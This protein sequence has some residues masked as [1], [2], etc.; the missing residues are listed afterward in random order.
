MKS[1]ITI[2]ES[3]IEDGIISRNKKFYP[4]SMTQEEIEKAFLNTRIKL[5][6]KYKFDGT[7]M[8]QALQ[9]NNLNKIEYPDGKYIVLTEKNMKKNDF[10]Y[11]QLPADIL[12]LTNKYKNTV[13]GH[14][15]ADCPILII[16]DRKLGVTALSH[17]GATYIDRELP[18]QTVE[19][20]IK[21]FN[22][23]KE[24][25][26]AYIGS[27]A[28]KENYI[29][30]NY[31]NWATNQEVWKNSI[32]NKNDKYYIDM[33]TAIIEQLKKKNINNIEISPID[34][35][36]DKNYYSHSAVIHGNEEKN[37]QNFV[38]FFYR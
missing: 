28:K 26:Y 14:Q 29:Y 34:T 27:C 30:D 7:K 10:W 19:A 6:E 22:S 8:F 21:E 1:Q 11:E 2:F 23:N 5:G 25:L 9:K 33:D 4:D 12:L 37:G 38:G 36:E 35:I 31:P 20:L 3:K 24:D 15:M 17:C 13:V 32:I 16:E 18:K